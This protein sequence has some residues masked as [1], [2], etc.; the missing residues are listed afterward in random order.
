MIAAFNMPRRSD[1][2]WAALDLDGTLA[3]G[4]WTPTTPNAGIGK[5]IEANRQKAWDLVEAG[6][7]AIIHTARP[8][9]DYELIEQYCYA[10]NIPFSGIVP[11]KLLAA[12]YIDD[13]AKNASEESWIPEVTNAIG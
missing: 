9:S 10:Y 13:R 11:G 12:V 4:I 3:E 2:K 1:L 6:Y 8:W 7:K 5:V